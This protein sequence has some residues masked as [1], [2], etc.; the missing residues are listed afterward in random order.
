V[1]FQLNLCNVHARYSL[2]GTN[3]IFICII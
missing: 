1:H 3:W 2:G